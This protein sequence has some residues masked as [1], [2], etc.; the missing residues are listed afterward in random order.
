VQADEKPIKIDKW[1][2]SALKNALDDSAKNVGLESA[3]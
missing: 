2:N 3:L 1:D